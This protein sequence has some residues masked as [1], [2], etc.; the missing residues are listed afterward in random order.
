MRLLKAKTIY[1]LVYDCGRVSSMV[2][3]TQEAAIK[4]A[5]IQNNYGDIHL[6]VV[7]YNPE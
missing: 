4:E 5:E 3:Y 6:R 7:K 1:L 2:F